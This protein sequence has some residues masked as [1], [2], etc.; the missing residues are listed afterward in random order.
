MQGTNLS[1]EGG[2]EPAMCP[3]I[4]YKGFDPF[5]IRELLDGT[6]TGVFCVPAFSA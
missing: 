4:W 1:G 2:E 3:V 5:S 6:D